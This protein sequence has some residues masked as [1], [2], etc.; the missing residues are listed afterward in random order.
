MSKI[1]ESIMCDKLLDFAKIFYA[2]K[3]NMKAYQQ[4]LIKKQ[5]RADVCNKCSADSAD[6]NSTC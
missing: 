6:K 3:K 1:L 5:A 4:L 2:D